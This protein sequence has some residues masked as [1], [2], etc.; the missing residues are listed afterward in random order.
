[1]TRLVL[2]IGLNDSDTPVCRKESGKIVW[3]CPLYIVWA[4]MLARCYSR[5]YQ[6]KRPT[7]IGCSVTPEWLTFSVFRDWM[8]RQDWNGMAMDKDILFPGNKVYSPDTCVFVSPA[9]N[10]FLTNS[11]AA[12]GERPTGVSWNKRDRKFASRCCNPFTGKHD[13]FGYFDCQD[14][15]HQAWRRAKHKH[16][17]RYA[18]QQSDPRIAEA[19]RARFIQ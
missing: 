11:G 1:M 19:L 12:K 13:Y 6:R 5:E 18:D 15:A 3:T 10:S 16:A 9:L 4:S 17:L 7:Y 2:G 14:A 8:E